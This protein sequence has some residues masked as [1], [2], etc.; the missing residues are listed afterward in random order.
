MLLSIIKGFL[1]VFLNK[2]T[3]PLAQQQTVSLT[4]IWLLGFRYQSICSQKWSAPMQMSAYLAT[5]ILA[6]QNPVSHC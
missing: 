1:P 2:S 4:L 3:V 6:W 5:T